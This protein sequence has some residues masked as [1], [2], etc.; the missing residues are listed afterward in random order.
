MPEITGLDSVTTAQIVKFE[1]LFDY[2]GQVCV[3]LNVLAMK[4]LLL[5]IGIIGKF[6]RCS[7]KDFSGYTWALRRHFYSNLN[8][9][10]YQDDDVVPFREILSATISEN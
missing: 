2:R 10:V 8:L 9:A 5:H 1:P 3:T 4:T 6:D 7:V